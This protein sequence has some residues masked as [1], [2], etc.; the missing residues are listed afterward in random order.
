M[1]PDHLANFPDSRPGPEAALDPQPPADNELLFDAIRAARISD[2]LEINV[3]LLRAQ[4]FSTQEITS[5]I[6]VGRNR[7]NRVIAHFR[8]AWLA[9]HPPKL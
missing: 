9:L 6:R 2:P 4:G 7:V 1:N 8:A 3:L 5:R